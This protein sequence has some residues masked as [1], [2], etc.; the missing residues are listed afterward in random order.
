[1]GLKWTSIFCPQTK[2]VLKTDDDIYV[3]VALL[4]R[5]IHQEYN[6]LSQH[7]Y[8]MVF[9]NLRGLRFYF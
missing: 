6:V 4:H 7:I 5:T 9:S 1:M 2:F 3:N 8:G